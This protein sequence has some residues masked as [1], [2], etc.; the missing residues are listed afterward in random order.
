[1]S[2]RDWQTPTTRKQSIY[3]DRTHVKPQARIVILT[4][5]WSLMTTRIELGADRNSLIEF[6]DLLGKLSTS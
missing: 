1:M 2:W 3:L 6:Y 4:F 5:W